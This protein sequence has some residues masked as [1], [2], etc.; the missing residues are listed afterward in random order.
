MRGANFYLFGVLTVALTI[1][2]PPAA[3]GHN[4]THHVAHDAA[5]DAARDVTTPRSLGAATVGFDLYRGYLIVARGSAGELHDR[6]FLL[7]T[8]ASTTI[9]DRQL[10]LALSLSEAPG[11]VAVL[12]GRVH[13]GKASL[14]SLEFGPLR[15]T[16]LPVLTEDLSFLEKGLA[17]RVDAVI[18]LDVL[19]QSA[20]V[21]DYPRR[22][23]RFGPLPSLANAI[24]LRLKEG[25]ATI[26]AEMNRAAVRLLVDTGA[27]SLILFETRLPSSVAGLENGIVRE[28]TNLNG[29]F[30]R[31]EVRLQS[32]KV[33]E[34][35][36]GRTPAF[37]VHDRR[38]TGRDFDGLMSPAALGI[39]TVSLDLTRGVVAFSR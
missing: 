3:S 10:A 7:D 30:T 23:I 31:K 21:V 22:E 33:G 35:D 15:K 6:N 11:S 2:K 28:S 39:K 29:T 18:G 38:D 36:F 12:D 14:P 9:L 8:G 5:H 34:T 26:D 17:V 13:A 16:E 1:A 37:V 4:A 20:F 24:P 25:L 27:S 32:L 19:E